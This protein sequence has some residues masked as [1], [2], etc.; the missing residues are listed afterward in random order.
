MAGGREY[1]GERPKKSPGRDTRAALKLAS[2]LAALLLSVGLAACG[3][4]KESAS[5]ESA[6]PISEATAPAA[7][8]SQG[9]QT[10]NATKSSS[11]ADNKAVRQAEEKEASNFVP[12][13]HHDSGGGSEKFREP[14]GGDNSIQDYGA[15]SFRPNS[16]NPLAPCT[17]ISTHGPPPIGPLPANT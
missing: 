13:H 6:T 11:Q 17:A 15:E 10:S 5:T 16:K 8:E 9:S 12:K 4:D 7:K 14:K 2:V 1:G 3:G